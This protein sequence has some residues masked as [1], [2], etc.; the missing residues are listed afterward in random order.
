[1]GK[2]NA[3]RKSVREFLPL[4]PQTILSID[5]SDNDLHW[6]LQRD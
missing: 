1:M 4:K 3:T 2:D 5:L 6:K